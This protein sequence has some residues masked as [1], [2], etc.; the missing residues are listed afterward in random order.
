ML[1]CFFVYFSSCFAMSTYQRAF[2]ERPGERL[3]DPGKKRRKRDGMMDGKT[4]DGKNKSKFY[5]YNC[6]YNYLYE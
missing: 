2:P 3:S 1:Y 6:L 4:W 5:I